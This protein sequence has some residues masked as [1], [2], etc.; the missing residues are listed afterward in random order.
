MASVYI[1]VLTELK[2]VFSKKNSLFSCENKAFKCQ[3]TKIPFFPLQFD[4]SAAGNAGVL[5]SAQTITSESIST[6]TTTHITKVKYNNV[7]LNWKKKKPP[8]K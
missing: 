8:L 6:T 1:S 5:L 2:N 3:N 4:G 7:S